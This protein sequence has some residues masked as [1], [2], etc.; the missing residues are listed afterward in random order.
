[1][2]FGHEL[3][4]IGREI[5]GIKFTNTGTTL[6]ETPMTFRH[7]IITSLVA[8]ALTGMRGSAAHEHSHLRGEMGPLAAQARPAP[9]AYVDSAPPLWPGLGTLS[10]PITTRKPLAQ[11]YFD[12]GLRLAYAF[13]HLEARRAFRH[14]QRLDPDCALCYWGE[15]LVLGPNINQPMQT[16]AIRPALAALEQAKRLRGKAGEKER[17]LIDALA[18]RYSNA[19]NAARPAL[20]QA[21]ANAMQALTKRYPQDV[22][23]AV[24][25]AE[26]LMNL[27]P[28][29]Y[30]ADEGR[31]A[32]GRTAEIV[33]ALENALRK[34]PDHPG[35]I[36]YYIHA[37]EASDKPERALPH[38]RRLAALMPGAGH[39][40]H[41][42]AHVYYRL[43]LYRE[44]LAANAEAIRVDESYLRLGANAGIYPESYFPHNI[45]FL[46]VSAQM[47]GDGKQTLAAAGKLKARIRPGSAQRYAAVQPIA[48]APYFAYAQYATPAEVLAL[49]DPG[50]APPYI[51]AMWH[52]ARGVALAADK[53]T[54]AA[55]REAR[56]IARLQHGADFSDLTAIG[57]PAR[58]VLKLAHHVVLARIAQAQGDLARAARE[59]EAAAGI[60]QGFPYMEPPYWYYPVHQSLG[61]TRLLLGQLD[62]AETAF[63]ASLE[64]TPNNAWAL[65]GLLRVYER[66][67][68][69]EAARRT[70]ARLDAARVGDAD[71]PGLRRL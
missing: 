4:W 34:S 47:A 13:N 52:Y 28:W 49:P 26:A 23:I 58:E 20:D 67:G 2:A 37:A 64:Q 31:R 46:L 6:M 62:R 44:S 21:Y 12:Q 16:E 65:S 50:Q 25:Y 56:A 17:D 43:G 48:A 10:Y 8:I 70:L 41:M 24:L 36:H 57:V 29:D 42:P 60:Q 15:A 9:M 7:L 38:A 71:L 33:A 11:R 69:R 39:I 66:R 53:Q 1:M 59:F 3:L 45:H 35:A 30:W 14:A 63:K 55:A 5:T 19:A 51:K 22:D 68:D 61:A 27:S 18:T 32:K 40:V 54:R